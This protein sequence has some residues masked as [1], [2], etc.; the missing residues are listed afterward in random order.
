M[1]DSTSRQGSRAGCLEDE[2]DFLAP[3]SGDWVVAEDR[4]RAGG[5]LLEACDQA[6]QR[7]F[8]AA[9][10]ADEGDELAGG[11]G[12]RRGGDGLERLA[13]GGDVGERDVAEFDR[14]AGRGH[15]RFL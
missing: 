9:A 3:L 10:G 4:D 12:E 1:F 14:V 7:G 15:R 5:R 8:A 2:A 6:Q 11:D 13:V